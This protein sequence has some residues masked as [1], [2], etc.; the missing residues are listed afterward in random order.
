V[1]SPQPHV[2]VLSI[3][4]RCPLHELPA[5]RRVLNTT[6]LPHIAR[7]GY[8]MLLVLLLG[9]LRTVA[10]NCYYPDG[11]LSVAGDG[12]CSKEGGACCP[13]HWQCMSNGLC[14]LENEVRIKRYKGPT[15]TE[16]FANPSTVRFDRHGGHDGTCR[17]CA[18]GQF[19]M[20]N[21]KTVNGVFR[22][23]GYGQYATLRT[24]AVVCLSRLKF[25]SNS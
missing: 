24:E 19:Q 16:T 20:C 15:L 21:N 7:A 5:L 2:P 22:E 18:R 4:P 3:S 13:L 9:A 11:S 14:F 6:M 8:A 12:P 1:P 17:A 25:R 23:G 10:T